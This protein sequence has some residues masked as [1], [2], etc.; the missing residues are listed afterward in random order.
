MKI[1]NV[2]EAL[3]GGGSVKDVIRQIEQAVQNMV[4]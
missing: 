4:R 3:S 1:L 2:N